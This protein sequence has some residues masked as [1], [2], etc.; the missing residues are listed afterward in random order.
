MK[1][2]AHRL[3]TPNSS[4]DRQIAATQRIRRIS[5]S[6]FKNK[7]LQVHVQI[8]I[9]VLSRHFTISPQSPLP[10]IT[11]T[12]SPAGVQPKRMHRMRTRAHSWHS[13]LPKR[14]PAQ[15]L[16]RHGA[17]QNQQLS[18]VIWKLRSVE[19]AACRFKPRAAALQDG[20]YARVLQFVI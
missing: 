3:Q 19:L 12:P 14:E 18:L 20:L 4:I 10:Q 5:R 7:L 6:V 16:R 8:Q 9:L 17:R 13:T 11:M 1:S 2:Y 15:Y